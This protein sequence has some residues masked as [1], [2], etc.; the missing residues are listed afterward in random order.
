[1]ILITRH[2]IFPPQKWTGWS[3]HEDDQKITMDGRDNPSLVAERLA[4]LIA[5]HTKPENLG[6]NP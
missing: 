5:R 3:A 1:M 4:G 6:A 2:E